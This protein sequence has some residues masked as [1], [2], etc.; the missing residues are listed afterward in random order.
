MSPTATPSAPNAPLSRHALLVVIAAAL[1]L[2][3]VM[4][5]RQT[6]GLFIHPFSY[7]RGLPVTVIAFAIALHNLV[8][9]FAQP[10]AGA[11]ADRYGAT[12]VVAFGAATFAGGLA[13]A[14]VAPSGLLLVLGLGVLVGI[15]ISCTSFGVV[16]AAVGR[17]ATPQQRSMAMGIASAGGSLGQVLLVPLAQ[18]VR[19]H[20]GVSMSLFVLAALTLLIAPAGIVLDRRQRPAAA[21]AP[22]TRND[23]AATHTMR[24]VP[25]RPTPNRCAGL[26]TLAF[27]TV[28]FELAFIG[29]HLPGY[30]L[31]CHMPLGLG[32]T[33]L[34]LIGLFNMAGSWGCGWLGGRFRQHYV[35]GWLYLI[36]S[37]AI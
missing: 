26:R 36:R 22:I 25:N 23:T 35:L 17:V 11:A 4:G 31:L 16:L 9:G 12:P 14:A 7:D 5:I 2:S 1:V 34:A 21:A 30:L 20:A 15:G 19:E 3:V 37:A 33:A 32:A 24:E 27:L 13:L 6:F 10:F 29:T 8:W 18:T 28:A